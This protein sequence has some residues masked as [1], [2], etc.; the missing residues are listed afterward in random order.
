MVKNMLA[1]WTYATVPMKRSLEGIFT[2][3]LNNQ[4]Q[5]KLIADAYATGDD[6]K[7]SEAL[8]RV[9]YERHPLVQFFRS[10]KETASAC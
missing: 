4:E 6:A 10:A 8:H 3:R 2:M 7:I 9:G 1:S 5:A